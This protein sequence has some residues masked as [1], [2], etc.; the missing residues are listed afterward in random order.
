MWKFYENQ[1]I[2]NI[3]STS[4]VFHCSILLSF[5]SCFLAPHLFFPSLVLFTYSDARYWLKKTRWA[6]E[7]VALCGREAFCTLAGSVGNGLCSLSQ[8]YRV[9]AAGQSCGWSWFQMPGSTFGKSFLQCERSRAMSAWETWK[10]EQERVVKPH[11][12]HPESLGCSLLLI[13]WLS[14]WQEWNRSF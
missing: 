3:S 6:Y 5:F 10:T 14:I 1:L 11:K 13:P 8:L 2:L 7:L 9:A 12:I 4:V